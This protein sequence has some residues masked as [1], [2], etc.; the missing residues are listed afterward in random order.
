MDLNGVIYDYLF[1]LNEAEN[2]HHVTP[3][4]TKKHFYISEFFSCKR[5]RIF[6][7]TPNIP[8][9]PIDKPLLYRFELGNK[10]ED[11]YREAFEK[12]GILKSTQEIVE[13]GEFSGKVDFIV[14]DM[15]LGIIELKTVHPWAFKHIKAEGA[16]KGHKAQVMWYFHKLKETALWKDL[17]YMKLLYASIADSMSL[18]VHVPYDH[19]FIQEIEQDKAEVLSY[20]STNTIPLEEPSFRCK[21]CVYRE[22]CKGV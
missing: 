2:V 18:E 1:D 3:E 12:K 13:D 7:R 4:G 15:G 9:V 19:G 5:K 17:K 10:W 8:K 21:K 16:Y 14:D 11:I 22:N 6:D 20:F